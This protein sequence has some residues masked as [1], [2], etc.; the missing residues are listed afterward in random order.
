MD[1]N[2]SFQD[3]KHKLHTYKLVDVL[4]FLYKRR[5]IAIHHQNWILVDEIN[6]LGQITAE[7]M[8]SKD[9]RKSIHWQ[10]RRLVQLDK[11]PNCEFCSRPADVVHHN[12]YFG[13]L[14][15]E[16]IGIDIKSLCY[17]CHQTQH[18]CIDVISGKEI[19]EMEKL[20]QIN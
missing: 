16:K 5:Q 12:K 6:H 9:Y 14:F 10:E 17:N 8:L 7:M 18:E 4:N 15:R 13:V 1:N 19:I 2:I 3:S 11:T 20:K